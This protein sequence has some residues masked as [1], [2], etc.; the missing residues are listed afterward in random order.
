MTQ[1]HWLRLPAELRERPQWL[2]AGP[3]ALGELKIPMTVG[4]T[5]RPEPGSHSD[6]AG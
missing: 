2:L 6:P 4:A 3:N 1:A 5:G